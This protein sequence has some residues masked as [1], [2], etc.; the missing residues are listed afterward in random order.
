MGVKGKFAKMWSGQTIIPRKSCWCIKMRTLLLWE[1]TTKKIY[2]TEKFIP[3][4]GL[5]YG[6]RGLVCVQ[7]SPWT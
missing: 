5:A 3:V 2:T 7:T 6:P 1:D 4:D